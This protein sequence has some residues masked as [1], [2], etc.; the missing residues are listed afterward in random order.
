MGLVLMVRLFQS[1]GL[2]E[3]VIVRQVVDAGVISKDLLPPVEM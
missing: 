2:D 1:S 3:A